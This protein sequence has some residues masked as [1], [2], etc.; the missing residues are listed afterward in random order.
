MNC[1]WKIQERKW[2]RELLAHASGKILDMGTGTG[3]NFE[4]YRPGVHVTAVDTG[5]KILEQAKFKAALHQVETEFILA[6]VQDLFFER[7]RFDTIVSTFSLSAYHEPEIVLRQ[8]KHWCKPDGRILL[9]EYGLSRNPVVNWLQQ[10]WEPR[11]YRNTGSHINRDMLALIN[12]SGLTI[13]KLDVH[14]AGIV[15]LVWAS[16]VPENI[17][18]YAY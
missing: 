12:R 18:V 17:N 10:R 9:L 15:Y 1:N 16:L 14:Y 3:D 5:S 8:Y 2:R 11:H 4:F 13:H 6:P 7:H